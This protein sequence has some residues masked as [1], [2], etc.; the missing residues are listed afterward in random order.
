MKDRKDICCRQGLYLSTIFI[1]FVREASELSLPAN[2]N[3]APELSTFGIIDLFSQASVQWQDLGSGEPPW[4]SWLT[5]VPGKYAWECFICIF[6]RTA[7]A[8]SLK[9][10]WGLSYFACQTWY[11]R[12]V[13][14][15]RNRNSSNSPRFED[16][17]EV[18][19]CFQTSAHFLFKYFVVLKLATRGKLSAKWKDG[20]IKQWC[21]NTQITFHG[22][23][24][25]EGGEI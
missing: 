6:D 10:A 4:G 19:Y 13:K 9:Y 20:Y 16:Q 2:I 3:Y 7:H 14:F 15:S 11:Q 17:L 12:I 24:G 5:P 21:T 22:Y 23:G 25:G 8:E 1:W 18:E